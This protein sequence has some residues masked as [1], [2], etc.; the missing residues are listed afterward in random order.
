MKAFFAVSVTRRMFK[1]GTHSIHI[2]FNFFPPT[3]AKLVTVSFTPH[4][5]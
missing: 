1:L 5:A 4:A 3:V 2:F